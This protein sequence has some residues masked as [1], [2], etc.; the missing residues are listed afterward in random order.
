MPDYEQC[1]F[2]ERIF[3]VPVGAEGSLIELDSPRRATPLDQHI[4]TEHHKVRL[5]KGSNYK[6]VD[7]A[8]MKRLTESWAEMRRAVASGTGPTKAARKH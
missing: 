1:Q 7:A 4:R 3:E 8:E 6:W 2:C 5:R